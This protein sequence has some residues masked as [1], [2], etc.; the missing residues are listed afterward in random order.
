MQIAAAIILT[1]VALFSVLITIAGLPGTWIMLLAALLAQVFVGP[2]GQAEMF[3]WWTLG[4]AGVLCILAEIAEGAAGGAGAAAAGAS[5]RAVFGG[6][7][8]GII[9]AIVG[10]FVIPIPSVGTILGGAIGAGAAGMGGGGGGRAT[11]RLAGA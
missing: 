1:F 5:K 7:V 3:S 9:G 10:T 11:G 2:E 6:I 4:V 8:G